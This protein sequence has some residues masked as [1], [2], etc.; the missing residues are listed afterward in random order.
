[1]SNLES[2]LNGVGN[3]EPQLAAESEPPAMVPGRVLH[4]DGDFLAYQVSASKKMKSVATMMYNFDVMVET[5]RLLAG[6]QSTV[7][8]LTASHSCKGGRYAQAIQTGYQQARAGKPKPEML[9]TIKSWMVKARGAISHTDQEADDAMCRANWDAIQAGQRELSIIVSKD[10]DL[11]ICQGLQMDWDEGTI[12]DVHGFGSIWLDRSKSSPSIKGEGNAYFWSQMLTG[13][14]AD[15]IKGLPRVC[16]PILEVVRPTTKTHPPCGPIL[17]Y[18]ILA[19]VD[20]DKDAYD[21]VSGLYKEY[22]KVYGFTHHLTDKPVS[23]QQVFIS[24][25]KMLWM[26][27]TSDQY[28]VLRYFKECK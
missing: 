11:R 1:M 6:A 7:S 16:G 18:D 17:A 27:R 2:L 8:H 10:K 12:K 26:R 3:L 21:L 15:T 13:D 24:E 14:S 5:F 22:E 9:E 4:I 28:D 25:A 20:T 19:D 23:W